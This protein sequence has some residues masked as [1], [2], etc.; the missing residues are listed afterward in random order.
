[1]HIV[2]DS[3]LILKMMQERKVL[4][5][6]KLQHWYRLARKLA[7]ECE[8][9]KWAH[10][11]RRHNKMANWLA[12]LAMDSGTSTMSAMGIDI[13]SNHKLQGVGLYVDGDTRRW[14]EGRTDR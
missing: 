10:H 13:E 3:A 12:N 4:K 2:G 8:V 9:R 6:R 14:I 1:M 11:Y 7:D 5:S